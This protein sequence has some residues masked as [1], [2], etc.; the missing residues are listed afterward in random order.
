[1]LKL[2]RTPLF[3]AHQSLGAR[4]VDFGGWEMPVQYKGIVAEHQ[5]VRNAAGIFDISHMGEIMVV[6]AHSACFLDSS[7]TNQ[8]SSLAV[9]GAQYSLMCN[10]HGG[11]IDDLYVYRIAKEVFLLIVNASRIEED[12]SQLQNLV[13]EYGKDRTVNVVNE[14]NQLSAVAVQGPNVRLFIDELFSMGGLMRVNKPSGLKKNQID[15]FT[16]EENDVYVANTGYTGESGFEIL[17]PNETIAELWHRVMKLGHPYGLEPAGLGARN[18]LRME[19]GYPLYGNELDESVTPIEAGLGY[20]V[21]LN[22]P[23]RGR[24]R[25]SEQNTNGLSRRNLAFQMSTKSPPPRQ[26][27]PVSA[28]GTTI[29]SVTS[30]TQSPSLNAG[31][32]MALIHEPHDKIGNSIEIE[33]RG[34]LFPAMIKGKPLYVKK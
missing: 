33:I 17:G 19:M 16:F 24:D 13:E 3:D 5:A 11:V 12:F 27:Y 10:T 34:Q 6:G 28:D 2:K 14:S 25:L 18:T 4:C 15:V 26:G 30:G 20:F 8:A 1:M 9:G 32:G 21:D 7:L 29:G 31:I 23:F 22:K